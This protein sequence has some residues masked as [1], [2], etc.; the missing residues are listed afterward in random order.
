MRLSAIVLQADVV[1]LADT[2]DLESGS[3]RSAGSSPVVG[4]IKL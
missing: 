3:V 1:K 4:T 2:P